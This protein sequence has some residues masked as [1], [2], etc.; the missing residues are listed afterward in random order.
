MAT[1]AT[2][3]IDGIDVVPLEAAD[4]GP[5]PHVGDVLVVRGWAHVDGGAAKLAVVVDGTAEYAVQT[6]LPRPDVVDALADPAALDSGFTVSVPTLDL[7]E[8][9]HVVTLVVPAAGRHHELARA[10]FHL[11]CTAPS[12]GQ[13]R[14]RGWLDSWTDESGNVARIAGGSISVAPDSVV[15]VDGWAA[16]TVSGDAAV[17]ALVQIGDHVVETAYGF[18]RPDV[19]AE[20]GDT[21]AYCGFSVSFPTTYVSAAGTPFRVM[22]LA[23]DGVTLRYADIVLTLF[24]A[25]AER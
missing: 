19:A 7:D 24:H 10:R 1:T 13:P 22:L 6:R 17:A 9:E 8:G 23:A 21:H 20:L 11:A 12:A 16:D 15:R 3:S 5:D 14:A 2:A 4:P 18:E 25:D